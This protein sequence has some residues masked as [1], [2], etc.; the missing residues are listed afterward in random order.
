MAPRRP[1]SPAGARPVANRAVTHACEELLE[2]LAYALEVERQEDRVLQVRDLLDHAGPVLTGALA[3]AGATA[4]EVQLLDLHGM[5]AREA[6]QAL[7]TCT[8][9]LSVVWFGKGQ[10]VLREIFFEFLT[11]HPELILVGT[12]GET[13]A[14]PEP[15]M[16]LILRR[17]LHDALALALREE[18]K[19]PPA[20]R[21]T[22]PTRAPR[23]PRGLLVR[24]VTALFGWLSRLLGLRR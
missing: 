5:R 14:R 4:V 19:A 20:T 23:V 9:P 21:P 8:E 17:D 10:G 16:G 11:R 24:L 3:R 6:K 1:P 15:A 18:T 2:H 22:R 7:L 13:E 12:S